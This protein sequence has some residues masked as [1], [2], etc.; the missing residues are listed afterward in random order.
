[1]MNCRSNA[2]TYQELKAFKNGLSMTAGDCGSLSQ[3]FFDNL[4]T[5]LGAV[6]AISGLKG[7]GVSDDT[8]NNVVYGKVVPGVGVSLFLGNVYYSWQAIRLSNKHGRQ[9]TA[10]PYGLNTPAAF[11]FVFNIIYSIYFQQIANPDV[12]P[13]DAFMLGYKVALAANFI[14]GLILIFLGCFGRLIL[15]VVPPAALLVPIAGLGI[16]FLGLEQLSY[17]IS[18]PIVGYPTIMWV[19]LGWFANIKI[20][21]GKFRIPEAV[22]V[23]LIGV[24][25]GWATGLNQP[26]KVQEAALLV[27]WWG[28][29]WTASDL[30]QDFG[31]VSDYLGIVI[32]IGISAAATT[33]MCLVSAKEAGDPFPVVRIWIAQR[34]TR[35]SSLSS[36][37]KTCS[38]ARFLFSCPPLPARVHGTSVLAACRSVSLVLGNRGSLLSPSLVCFDR[39]IDRFACSLA[40]S[41][42]FYL[43]SSWTE[44]GPPSRPSSGARSGPSSTSGTPCTSGTGPRSGTRW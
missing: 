40:R 42:C 37:R 20:G 8:V 34:P 30:F 24:I 44:S 6:I 22:T 18:A 15:K 31:L 28:P 17:S 35:F 1:M 38:L 16:S 10:Q 43:T 33:L 25:L 5:L 11:A 19:Y 36:S 3:L 27:R 23:I 14:T 9:Y 4:S 2:R 7:T 12:N 41:S 39:S 26:E 32:P 29:T 13:D 21:Y